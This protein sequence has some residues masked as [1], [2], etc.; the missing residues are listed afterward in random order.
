M[1]E[2]IDS[3]A[4]SEQVP[5]GLFNPLNIT[6]VNPESDP[7]AEPPIVCIVD[8]SVIVLI[9]VIIPNAFSLI[10]VKLSLNVI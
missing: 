9:S 10:V 4:M 8:G 6:V 5:V 7:N 3:N 2:T 1:N